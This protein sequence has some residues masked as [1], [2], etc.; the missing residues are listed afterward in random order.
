MNDATLGV[1]SARGKWRPETPIRL[2]PIFAWPPRP[3]MG[4]KWTF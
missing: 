3:A 1:R 4:L 2:P